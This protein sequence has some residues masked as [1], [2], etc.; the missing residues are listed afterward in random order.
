MPKNRELLT[1]I[2]NT[3]ALRVAPRNVPIRNAALEAILSANETQGPFEDAVIAHAAFWGGIDHT[4]AGLYKRPSVRGDDYIEATD[5]TNTFRL[6][7]QAAA[8]QR[9]KFALAGA[10]T[11][12]LVGLLT[13]DYADNGK[14]LRDY[15][16]LKQNALGLT[17]NT[18]PGWNTANED[19]LTK[20][21]LLRVRTEAANQVL[22]Q[23]I[24]KP[25]LTDPKL[26]D[27]L[28]KATN[29]RE[30]QAAAK[31]LATAGGITPPTT[32]DKLVDAMTFADRGIVVDAATARHKTLLD[33]KAITEFEKQLREFRSSVT[34]ANL[35]GMQAI[36]SQR[37]PVNFFDNLATSPNLKEDGANLYKGRM[38]GVDD[39]KKQKFANDHQQALCEQYL[40]AKIPTVAPNGHL[41]SALKA[42]DATNLRT[43]LKNFINVRG[44]DAIIDKAVTDT[45]VAAIKLAL[46]KDAI[47]HLIPTLSDVELKK[48][49]EN[50][51]N[52]DSFKVAMN[53]KVGDPNAFDFLKKEDLPELR[54]AIREGV[55]VKARTKREADFDAAVATSRLGGAGIHAQLKVV[56][57]DLPSE[58]QKE[59]FK[60]DGTVDR[61][62]VDVL[63]NAKTEDRLHS[64][65]GNKNA[66]GQPLVVAGLAAENERLALLRQI[67]NPEIAK[68]LAGRTDDL[69][70]DK[71]DRINAILLNRRHNPGAV[72]PAVPFDI[73]TAA[74]YK[75]F[76]TEIATVLG[77]GTDDVFHQAFNLTDRN[78]NVL[79][80]AGG[81]AIAVAVKARQV[82][83]QHLF[84][85][86]ADPTPPPTGLTESQKK[87]VEIFARVEGTHGL[88][89][90]QP[91]TVPPTVP[92]P[93]PYNMNSVA[94][95]KKIV[96]TFLY[97]NDPDGFLD[98]LIPSPA[99]NSP[100]E[101]MKAELRREFTPEQFRAVED[102]RLKSN[103]VGPMATDEKRLKVIKEINENLDQQ[104][105]ITPKIEKH[106]GHLDK[107]NQDLAIL[108][109]LFSKANDEIAKNKAGKMIGEYKALSGQCDLLIEHLATAQ[110]DLQARLDDTPMPA[111]DP[112]APQ[113]GA[114]RKA[115]KELHDRLEKELAVIDEQLEFYKGVQDKIG[116]ALRDIDKMMK[117]TGT[118][119]VETETIK[120][121]VL[122]KGKEKASDTAIQAN[123]S[124]PAPVVHGT[125]NADPDAPIFKV[126]DIPKAGQVLA[127]DIT[128]PNPTTPGGAPVSQSRV[129]VD[130][131]PG[132]A[133][134]D[135]SRPIR[136]NIA[137]AATGGDKFLAEQAMEAAKNLLKDWN[138]KSP[139]RLNGVHGK[140]KQLQFLWTAVCRLGEEHP[141][142]SRDKIEF[143]GTS[144]W[145]P[146]NERSFGRYTAESAYKKV[147]E[148]SAKSLVDAKVDEFKALVNKDKRNAIDKGVK[149]ATSLFRDSL[150]E[151][152]K[153]DIA[154][155]AK[156]D[157]AVQGPM[158][159][160]APTLGGGSDD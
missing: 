123:A 107:L 144:S 118:A 2:R 62:K 117:G 129:T 143:R 82:T 4:L 99:A 138:G 37:D 40:K 84:A 108:P 46:A 10:P 39:P 20:D 3:T 127:I 101:K 115:T 23:L 90:P 151:G 87:L 133:N 43:H 137:E 32:V 135:G 1:A 147:F 9:V 106:K 155:R 100:E 141:K 157:I 79:N 119:L 22:I 159:S 73:N 121:T 126:K 58:K 153:Q 72:H 5:P 74:D 128:H 139:I 97:H 83:N 124:G 152:R 31:A 6:M 35:L 85:A 91:A 64:L 78:S 11:D 16:E 21:A 145:R 29:E 63:I 49:Q 59:L 131:H 27:D 142:F 103:F 92:A 34:D 53:A 136:V 120:Y 130:Y 96:E 71:I 114:V 94:G 47:K 67:S 28:V 24:A 19:I 50:A 86:L 48:L 60:A 12:A 132:P 158:V 70:Q 80:G 69:D 57:K 77:K 122:D 109:N 41:I 110:R 95:I 146:D 7:K 102:L 76:I 154:T 105:K 89:K 55:D 149:S 15:L 98:E 68:V 14:Q 51:A 44:D 111:E 125:V 81:N 36:L 33:D 75:T 104:E 150:D 116:G 93:P 148:G 56:F 65:L 156:K 8:E 61:Q 18:V 17:L 45:N 113:R 13:T 112:T 52:L 38:P 66:K 25:G 140:D 26:F 88:T 160:R 30:L 54:A 42:A 134:T